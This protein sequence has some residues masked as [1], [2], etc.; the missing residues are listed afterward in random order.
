M[1]ILNDNIT[2]LARKPDGVSI[3]QQN[4]NKIVE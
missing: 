3:L 2:I 4:S 1:I